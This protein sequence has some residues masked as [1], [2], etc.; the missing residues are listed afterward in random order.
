MYACTLQTKNN[1][2]GKLLDVICDRDQLERKHMEIE[3]N[4]RSE[5]GHLD[6]RMR[7]CLAQH[8]VFDVRREKVNET[9]QNYK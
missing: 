2:K 8:Y 7:I 3:K 5:T 9:K 1:K 6:H 4:T